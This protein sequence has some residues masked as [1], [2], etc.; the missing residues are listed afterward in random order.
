[1]K[2]REKS[3]IETRVNLKEGEISLKWCNAEEGN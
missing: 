3:S 2:K 1:M